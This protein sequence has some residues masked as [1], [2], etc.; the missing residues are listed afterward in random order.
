MRVLGTNGGIIQACRDRPGIG[1]LPIAVLQHI[2]FGAVQDTW[3]PAQ[4]CRAMLGTVEAVARR[5]DAN[6]PH[7]IV[8]EISEQAD[9]VGSTTDAGHHCVRQAADLLDH[10]RARLTADHALE[11]AHHGWERMRARSGPE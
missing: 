7:V 3:R 9:G 1:D 8:E 5:L 10:L 6:Q 4:Q 11:F 2:S